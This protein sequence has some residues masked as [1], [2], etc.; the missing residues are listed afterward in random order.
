MSALAASVSANFVFAGQ[1]IERVVAR[2]RDAGFVALEFQAIDAATA[3]RQADTIANAGLGVA[4]VNLAVGDL[5][6]GGPG[7]AAVPARRAE[8]AAAL[9]EGTAVARRLGPA[10]VH[11]GPSRIPQGGDGAACLSE[12]VD[13]IHR[14]RDALAPLGC[15]VSVE[16]LNS[17]EFPGL[18]LD[19]IEAAA[20]LIMRIEGGGVVLQYDLY[21]AA[22]DGRDIARDIVSFYPL[23]GHVQFADCPGRGEPGTGNLDLASCFAALRAAGYRGYVGAEYRPSRA[24][25]FGWMALLQGE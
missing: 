19:T 23:I 16:V 21:H 11:V 25:D 5:A 17:A 15:Q 3:D 22:M 10:V 1:P 12:L 14:A 6:A 13:N 18:A 4:L 20:E 7:L 2:A 9:E 8:F 24:D